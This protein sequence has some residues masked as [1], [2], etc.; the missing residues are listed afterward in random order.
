[1]PANAGVYVYNIADRI[2]ALDIDIHINIGE[3]K[4]DSESEEDTTYEDNAHKLVLYRTWYDDDAAWTNF[5]RVLAYDEYRSGTNR[6]ESGHIR[7]LT[8]EEFIGLGLDDVPFTV[9]EDR[10]TLD[11]AS[12]SDVR[13]A[14]R[15]WID[16]LSPERDGPGLSSVGEFEFERTPRYR[17]C[18]YAERDVIMSARAKPY[19]NGHSGRAIQ[20]YAIILDAQFKDNPDLNP[21]PDE[22]DLEAIAAGEYDDHDE[23]LAIMIQDYVGFDPI[24]G[25]EARDVGWF[26]VELVCIN[27]LGGPDGEIVTSL[28]EWYRY[29]VR[30]PRV[31]RSHRLL[32][33]VLNRYDVW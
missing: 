6:P 24:E 7:H 17:F 4:S 30:P 21:V 1:M 20:G 11:G 18:V 28:V 25:C 14:F 23:W 27:G 32:E 13:N 16:A 26:Y 2:D 12:K 19:G 3:D 15:A 31:F 10:S 9:I 33:D 29:Y 8:D 5:L 22:E